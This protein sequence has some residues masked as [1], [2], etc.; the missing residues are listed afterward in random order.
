M[1]HTIRKFLYGAMSVNRP[2]SLGSSTNR[3]A[4]QVR[5]QLL[6]GIVKKCRSWIALSFLENRAVVK[7]W[8]FQLFCQCSFLIG[9]LHL[10]KST[11][12]WKRLKKIV[13]TLPVTLAQ[14]I[15]RETRQSTVNQIAETRGLR[16]TLHI[17]PA[18][19]ET[20]F[21]FQTFLRKFWSCNLTWT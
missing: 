3:R 14:A 13:L 12:C 4:T 9:R 8:F 1:R 7:M 2:I 5:L 11:S 6:M 17:K 15:F 10:R 18:Q 19:T 21:L 20:F 16:T